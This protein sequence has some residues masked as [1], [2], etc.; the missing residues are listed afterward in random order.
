MLL[1]SL[2]FVLDKIVNLVFVPKF[3]GGGVEWGLSSAI[4]RWRTI[5]LEPRTQVSSSCATG[6]VGSLRTG[7]AG[8]GNKCP[9]VLSSF[10]EGLRPPRVL[11]LRGVLLSVLFRGQLS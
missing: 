7:S 3:S 10:K 8:T 6:S 11:F 9:H 5:G 1:L 4:E 2:M